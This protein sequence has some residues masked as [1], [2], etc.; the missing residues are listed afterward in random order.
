MGIHTY[1]LIRNIFAFD[2]KSLTR[3]IYNVSIISSH[4]VTG[5]TLSL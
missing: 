4:N 3:S 1:V 5:S 2:V